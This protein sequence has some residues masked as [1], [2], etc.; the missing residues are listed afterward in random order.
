MPNRKVYVAEAQPDR[1][2]LEWAW[3]FVDALG[4][5]GFDVV[6]E[7]SIRDQAS[8]EAAEQGLRESDLVVVLLDPEGNGSPIL[9]FN[10]GVALAGDKEFV[11]VLPAG[12]AP[13]RLEVPLEDDQYVVRGAPAE[14][15]ASVA[16]RSMAQ[17]LA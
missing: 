14:T 9:Y 15:A 3:R 2:D 1:A 11:A 8:L 13:D 16:A 12:V 6:T 5:H 17:P 4:D 7:W 10:Y